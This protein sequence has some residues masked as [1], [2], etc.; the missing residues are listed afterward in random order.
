[1][2][3]WWW[4]GRGAERANS[5]PCHAGESVVS[6]EPHSPGANFPCLEH[7][8]STY[9]DLNQNSSRCGCVGSAIELAFQYFDHHCS[10][11]VCR[12][13]SLLPARVALARSIAVGRVRA[14]LPAS[15]DETTAVATVIGVAAVTV[16]C[17]GGAAV[18]WA[19]LPSSLSTCADGLAAEPDGVTTVVTKATSTERFVLFV[20]RVA[21]TSSPVG[22]CPEAP[23]VGPEPPKVQVVLT[24]CASPP[25]VLANVVTSCASSDRNVCAVMLAPLGSDTTA[26]IAPAEISCSNRTNF[27][28]AGNEKSTPPIPMTYDA[29]LSGRPG[30]LSSWKNQKSFFDTSVR[31]KCTRTKQ[32][33]VRHTTEIVDH[34][35]LWRSQ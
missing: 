29:A 13:C 25:S 33:V 23:V 2:S 32:P 3:K 1:M 10:T 24:T 27:V 31:T 4:W 15:M 12:D 30:I 21:Q 7:A 14:M 26:L 19:D 8:P 22:S 17:W 20:V 34:R 35:S 11:S 5:P 9:S 18:G 16:I 28:P 6:Q